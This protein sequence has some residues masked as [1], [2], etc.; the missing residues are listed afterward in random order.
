[1]KIDPTTHLLTPDC[2]EDF[3]LPY[4]PSPN[5]DPYPPH[6]NFLILHYTAG[7]SYDAAANWL[8]NPLAKASAHLIIARDAKVGQL[9]PFNRVAW[10]AGVSTWEQD[11]AVYNSL[12]HHSIGIELDNAGRLFTHHQGDIY[13]SWFGKLYRAEDVLR[14]T[15]E[16]EDT[17]SFW[18]TYTSEQLD[19]A[20][21]ISA[22]IMDTYGIPAVLGHDQISVGRKFDP[23]PAFPMFSFRARLEG[24]RGECEC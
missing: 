24:R 7:G 18:H 8:R 5:L 21:H 16:N 9:V 17:P 22:L 20:L 1:M 11:G 15:H 13:K 19:R 2:G 6:Y 23:G 3:L 14:A 4:I 10:H 12:N